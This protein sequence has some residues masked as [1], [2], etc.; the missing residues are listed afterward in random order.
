M[1]LIPNPGTLQIRNTYPAT[2]PTRLHGQRTEARQGPVFGGKEPFPGLPA[3]EG[4]CHDPKKH[5]WCFP[6][7]LGQKSYH[8]VI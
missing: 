5:P 7:G 2:C 3:D 4:T 1:S 6:G 8:E